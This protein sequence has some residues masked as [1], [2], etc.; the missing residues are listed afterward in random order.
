RD[1][2]PPSRPVID[3]VIV[4]PGMGFSILQITAYVPGRGEVELLKAPG[5]AEAERIYREAPADRNRTTNFG[6]GVFAPYGGT[7]GRTPAAEGRTVSVTVAGKPLDLPVN[8]GDGA[9]P[10]FAIH[11]FLHTRRAVVTRLQGD[12][13][14]ASV[15][16][17]LDAGNFDVGW[18]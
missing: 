2:V 5:V 14:G 3:R 13:R 9:E 1:T 18:P 8:V 12:D 16:A 4:L 15:D 6:A 11:G 10:R 17:T 7:D